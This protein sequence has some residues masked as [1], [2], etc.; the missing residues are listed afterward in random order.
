MKFSIGDKVIL[1][2][3]KITL[4]GVVLSHTDDSDSQI[5]N[6]EEYLT[7]RTDDNKV[8]SFQGKDSL[9]PKAKS[10]QKCGRFHAYLE[11]E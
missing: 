9:R 5:A 3:K 6:I 4:H 11:E 2:S 10:L 7:I 1:K 8:Y